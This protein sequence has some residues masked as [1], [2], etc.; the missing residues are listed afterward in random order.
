MQK[1]KL[2]PLIAAISLASMS[3]SSQAIGIGKVSSP[4]IL[5]RP[6]DIELALIAETYDFHNIHATLANEK[7]HQ[8]FGLIYPDWMPKLK[9]NIVDNTAGPILKV[10]TIKP[11]KEPIVNFII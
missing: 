11:I 7:Q 10:T 4:S 5:N 1:S 3:L 9:F 8:R 2:L 6:L